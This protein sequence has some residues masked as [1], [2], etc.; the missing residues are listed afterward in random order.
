MGGG[1]ED[2]CSGEGLRAV[3]VVASAGVAE[4]QTPEIRTKGTWYFCGRPR[5]GTK[6]SVKGATLYFHF[7]N[8]TSNI[9]EVVYFRRFV[10]ISSILVS[11]CVVGFVSKAPAHCSAAVEDCPGYKSTDPPRRVG[12]QRD[13]RAVGSKRPCLSQDSRRRPPA[14]DAGGR[15]RPTARSTCQRPS[16]RQVHDANRSIGTSTLRRGRLPPCHPCPT[17]SGLS[18]PHS[19]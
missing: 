8:I 4:E 2:A 18:Q 14:D 3:G 7:H 5:G 16:A 15:C 6:I 13:D 12:V 11:R 17:P 9:R 1:G 10:S 19:S